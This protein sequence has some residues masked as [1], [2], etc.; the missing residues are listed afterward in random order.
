MIII[1]LLVGSTNCIAQKRI[2]VN[3]LQNQDLG[4]H[5]IVVSNPFAE[6]FLGNWVWTNGAKRLEVEIRKNL[7]KGPIDGKKMELEVINGNYKYTINGRKVPMPETNFMRS[8]TV[9]S[10]TEPLVF[11]TSFKKPS[12]MNYSS[13]VVEMH[14]IDDSTVS[15][16]YQPNLSSE[17]KKAIPIPLDIILKRM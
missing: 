16:K 5:D 17:H 8:G 3:E 11:R 12:S 6:K 4:L 14:Y 1:A 10:K 2:T 13:Y 15:L 7:L 9:T